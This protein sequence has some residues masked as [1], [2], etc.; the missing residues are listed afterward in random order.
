MSDTGIR[1]A[2]TGERRVTLLTY[3]ADGDDVIRMASNYRITKHPAWYFNVKSHRAVTL[4]AGGR[5]GRYVVRETTNAEGKQGCQPSVPACPRRTS[6][7]AARRRSHPRVQRLSDLA[8][9]VRRDVK[10]R[11][12]YHWARWAAL[13]GP[14]LGDELQE[15]VRRRAC[16][17]SGL[18][19]PLAQISVGAAQRSGASALLVDLE[20]G[21][22]ME[23]QT[24]V[25]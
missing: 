2:H 4:L 22:G 7:T 19:A 16:R 20:S 13:R 23:R 1:C 12:A 3:F 24:F 9:H 14:R 5:E 10:L 8:A 25:R 15:S 6:R 21:P 17:L 18:R 11:S